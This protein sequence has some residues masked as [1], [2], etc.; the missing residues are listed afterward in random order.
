MCG[1]KTLCLIFERA[2]QSLKVQQFYR[3]AML[4]QFSKPGS[5]ITHNATKSESKKVIYQITR[6][7]L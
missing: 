5:Y 1:I 2:T 7:F 6:S 3:R 4:D